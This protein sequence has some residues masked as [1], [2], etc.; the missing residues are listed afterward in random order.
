MTSHNHTCSRRA[1]LLG[2]ATTFA[3][4]LLVACGSSGTKTAA[5][6]VPVGSAIITDDAII[7]RP[8]ADGYKVYST[9]CPHQGSPITQ[10][11]GDTV[12]CTRHGSVFSIKD[13][14]VI[15]GP[16]QAGLSP[17]E[18]SKDGDSIVVK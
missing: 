4:A 17:K 13:G 12:K 14:S 9:V 16:S 5:N 3:G 11:S 7:A 8:T 1:F 6:D 18:F 2:T 15:S 10:V